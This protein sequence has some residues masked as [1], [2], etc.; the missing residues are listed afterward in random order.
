[1]GKGLIFILGTIGFLSLLTFFFVPTFQQAF[2]GNGTAPVPVYHYETIVSVIKDKYTTTDWHL[3]TIAPFPIYQ[4]N[5][6]YNFA[7]T[8]NDTITVSETD[9][10]AHSVG[11]NFTYVA[12]R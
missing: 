7:M 2:A 9:Y 4:Y 11:D 12:L 8:N 3:V 5:P 6:I 10:Y 1:V